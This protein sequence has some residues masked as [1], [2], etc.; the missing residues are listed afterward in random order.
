MGPRLRSTCLKPTRIRN[1]AGAAIDRKIM[2][3]KNAEIEKAVKYCQE[4]NV[5]GYA[6][7]KTNLFPNIKEKGVI[8]RRL[9][10]VVRHGCERNYCRILTVKEE[11]QLVEYIKHKNRSYQ[12]MNRKDVTR[13][14][15]N[16]LKVRQHN[17]KKL[18]F[19]NCTPLST[20]AKDVLSRGSL[21][22]T[23]LG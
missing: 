13:V 21:G 6:A 17:N 16:I 4:N 5:N 9:K 10:G 1:K 20:N 15:L 2:D 18:N 12:P 8:D 22:P 19:R 3:K 11:N 23:L 14:I 7:L